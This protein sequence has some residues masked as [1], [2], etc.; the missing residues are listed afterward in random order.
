[1][2][3]HVS[4]GSKKVDVPDVV[5][6]TVSDAVAI[7]ENAGFKVTKTRD[8]SG[9]AIVTNQSTTG[10]AEDGATINITAEEQDDDTGTTT[11]SKKNSG[12]SHNDDD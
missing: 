11:S 1:M 6:Y 12:T 9:D 7:L 4:L 8:Y 5:G 10:E 2:K 3:I